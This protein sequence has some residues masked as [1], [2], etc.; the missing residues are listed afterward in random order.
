MKND[1]G[2]EQCMVTI[3]PQGG[4]GNRIRSIRAAARVANKLE[5]KLRII[6]I[7]VCSCEFEDIFHDIRGIKNGFEVERIKGIRIPDCLGGGNIQFKRIDQSGYDVILKDPWCN[8]FMQTDIPNHG[9][10]LLISGGEFFCSEENIE[11]IFT[12][13]ICKIANELMDNVKECVGIHI[14]Q[15]D[16]SKAIENSP[17]QL[18]IDMME[19][20]VKENADICF[21]VSTDDKKILNLLCQQFFG[22]CLFYKEKSWKRYTKAGQ[23]SAA[24]E[25]LCLAKTKII[26]GSYWSSFSEEAAKIGNIKKINLK[27]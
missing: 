17:I 23:I 19:N 10:I 1:Y 18:F 4:L 13:Q 3:V 22:K 15:G 26:Y 25:L 21:Y 27:G 11:F 20:I 8:K 16:N 6:W 14:R 12:S 24:V 9:N 2:G 5:V 7:N